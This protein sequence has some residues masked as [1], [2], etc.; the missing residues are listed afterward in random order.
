MYFGEGVDGDAPFV[1]VGSGAGEL[2]YQ[3]TA[4]D[5]QEQV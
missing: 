5:D 3:G 1:V 2:D 4:A